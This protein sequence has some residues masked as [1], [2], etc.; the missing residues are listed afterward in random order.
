VEQKLKGYRVYRMESPRVNGPGQPVT[1]VTAEPV[2]ETPFADPKA[3]K[4]TRRYWVVAVDALGQEGCRRH[5]RGTTG[6]TNG[7]TSRLSG[8]GISEK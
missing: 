8:S 1:R 3:G 6:S 2:S 7:S 5:R 4:M